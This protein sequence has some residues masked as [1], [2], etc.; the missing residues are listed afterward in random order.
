MKIDIHIEPDCP[1]LLIAITTASMTPEV[2]QLLDRIQEENP[3]RLLGFRKE[4]MRILEREQLVRIYTHN[5]KVIADTDIGE[6]DLR[7]RLYELEAQL[8]GSRFVRISQSEL[9]NLSK[10]EKFDL[11]YTGTICVHLKN[12]VVTSVSRRYLKKI[13]QVLGL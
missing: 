12:G 11:R 3:Q 2:E 1:E 10:V 6:Y 4:E 5:G 13:K 7:Q 9:I 8:E